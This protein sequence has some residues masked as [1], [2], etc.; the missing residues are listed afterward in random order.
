MRSGSECGGSTATSR[1]RARDSVPGTR[2]APRISIACLPRWRRVCEFCRCCCIPICP[3]RLPSCSR[4]LARPTLPT[5]ALGSA[6]EPLSGWRRSRRCSRSETPTSPPCRRPERRL[7]TAR[8]VSALRCSAA[9]QYERAH[10]RDRESQLF[11]FHGQ[12]AL[13]EE[14]IPHRRQLLWCA[15][16]LVGYRS[17][18]R[19]L[20]AGGSSGDSSQVALL[21]RTSG[22]PAGGIEP[23][24]EL[25]VGTRKCGFRGGCVDALCTGRS[26]PS[27]VPIKL[28]RKRIAARRTGQYKGRVLVHRPPRRFGG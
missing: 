28:N 5:P 17:S 18:A 7:Q 27:V 9:C 26:T 25:F 2:P 6:M 1:S 13:L 4:R 24:L 23:A 12:R 15:A 19:S 21:R 14:I 20:A 16:Q 11:P 10:P 22:R 8:S 3:P